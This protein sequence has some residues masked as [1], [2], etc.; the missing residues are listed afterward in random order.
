MFLTCLSFN[1]RADFI[2]YEGDVVMT[3]TGLANMFG[4]SQ[5]WFLWN[6]RTYIVCSCVTLAGA[7]K[8]HY[9]IPVD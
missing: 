9:Y 4:A 2:D 5:G 3:S 8:K 7:S 1:A 6:G